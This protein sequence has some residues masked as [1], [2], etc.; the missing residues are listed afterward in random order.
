[1][2]SNVVFYFLFLLLILPI[3]PNNAQLFNIPN[4]QAFAWQQ[5][6]G[7]KHQRNDGNPTDSTTLRLIDELL[8]IFA[9]PRSFV[10]TE[11][12]NDLITN[13]YS[14]DHLMP[15]MARSE[16][17]KTERIEL[18]SPTNNNNDDN[19]PWAHLARG[20][21]DLFK[22][23]ETTTPT[24]TTTTTTQLSLLER[25]LP[26]I[27]NPFGGETTTMTTTPS[28]TFPPLFPFFA[29][30]TT[31]AQPSLF[32]FLRREQPKRE[33][34]NELLMRP[35]ELLVEQVGRLF[36]VERKAVEEG[37]AQIDTG[38]PNFDRFV[39][40]QKSASDNPFASIVG[41]SKWNERGIKWEDGNIRLVDKNGNSLLGTEVGV[42]D[43]SVDIPLKRW[44]EIANGIVNMQQTQRDYVTKK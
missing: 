43:R 30:T 36:G 33:A 40:R 17:Y 9:P 8:G 19:Q 10:N 32:S 42:N 23:I 16:D 29:R 2:N 3:I 22:S 35:N 28:S 38:G 12:N 1:M 13:E 26:K 7:Q 39:V 27:F 21:I 24:T 15:R 11:R 44:L 31:T 34:E 41:G 20:V 4:T 14:N 37:R 6:E 18:D 5:F 25:I